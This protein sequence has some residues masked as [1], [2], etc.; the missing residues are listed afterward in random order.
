MATKQQ[1]RSTL[2]AHGLI[3]RLNAEGGEDG[4]GDRDVVIIDGLG[5]EVRAPR[6]F[7]VLPIIARYSLE[8]ACLAD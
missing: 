5:D 3:R 7:Q 1:P 2:R 8:A 6:D 4:E